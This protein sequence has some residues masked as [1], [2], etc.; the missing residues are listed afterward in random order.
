[1]FRTTL[2]RQQD[3]IP[4]VAEKNGTIGIVFRRASQRTFQGAAPSTK[5]RDFSTLSKV[6]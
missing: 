4:N 3:V 2:M 5:R 6:Q 1:M